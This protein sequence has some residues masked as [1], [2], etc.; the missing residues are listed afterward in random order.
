VATMVSKYKYN[1]TDF[2]SMPFI[3]EDLTE[4]Y[5]A[6][7]QHRLTKTK[8][9][10]FELERLGRNLFFTVKHRVVEGRLTPMQ[11]EE[12]YDYLEELMDD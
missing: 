5:H 7:E 3:C 9:T 4:F 11:A 12:I 8:N 2:A 10:R 6:H 1:P